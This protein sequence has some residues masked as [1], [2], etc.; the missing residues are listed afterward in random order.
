MLIGSPSGTAITIRATETI[1]IR[2]SSL[3]VWTQSPVESSPPMYALASIAKKIAIDTAI[4]ILPIIRERR[5]N[6]LYSGV[7]SSLAM[8]DCSVTRPAS[9]RSPTASAIISP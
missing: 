1:K 2:S 5:V 6:C 9:V 4:P 8:D 3:E 7:G